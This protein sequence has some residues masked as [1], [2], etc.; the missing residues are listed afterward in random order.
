MTAALR[1]ENRLLIASIQEIDM[2]DPAVVPVSAAPVAQA[3]R[4]MDVL[5]WGGVL[6]G[7]SALIRIAMSTPEQLSL[8]SIPANLD[9]LN[10]SNLSGSLNWLTST[11]AYFASEGVSR[12]TSLADSLSFVA[13]IVLIFAGAVM[14]IRRSI[15]RGAMVATL[16]LLLL[17]VSASSGFAMDVRNMGQDKIVTVPAGQTVDDSLFATGDTVIIDGIING[18][19]IAFARHVSIN[20]TIKG[21]LIT[22]GSSV[23]VSGIVEGSIL[24]GGQN[25]QLNGKVAH[26]LM[27]IGTITIGKDAAIGGDAA[28]FGNEIHMNGNI[29]RSFYAFGITDIAGTIGRNVTFRG[30]TITVLPSA[31]ISG[32]LKSYVPRAETVHIDPSATIGG[33][34]TVELPKPGPSRYA[35]F[36]FYFSQLLHVAAAFVAGFLL[37]LIVPSL[38]RLG[39]SDSISVLK[40]GGIGFLLVFATPI[41]ALCVAITVVGL[42]VAFVGFVTWLLGLYLAKIVVANF[43][44]RTLLASQGD[45]MTSVALGLL[46]GLVLIF[47]AINLPYVGGLI[48]FVLVLIGFGAL[49]MNVYGSFRAEPGFGR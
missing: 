12:M 29:A 9:W 41:A 4:P 30:S 13:L 46:V 34:Q 48:E 6:I 15:S 27:S 32:D 39:F 24:I 31:R 42:P 43:I 5:K 26:N 14:L 16:G 25:I 3:A 7:L 18:D 21:N 19:L 40:S 17:I 36:S 1:E 49:A 23:D 35:T 22:A 38:R 45:R 2:T 11:I 20:G 28:G 33:K 37:L 44:G 8:P 47:V 10:P